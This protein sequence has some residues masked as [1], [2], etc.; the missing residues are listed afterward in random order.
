MNIDYEIFGVALLPII[1]GLVEIIKQFN[2]PKRFV[3]IVAI[4]I[5]EIV[6]IVFL[7]D[8]YTEIKKA[9]I[10]GL[11]MGLASTGLYAGV[12]HTFMYNKNH[13]TNENE[14][15]KNEIEK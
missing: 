4:V 5:S 9:V 12:K 15:K 7:S 11:Q 2:L 3:P 13:K 8:G 10:I 1:V 6:A 14:L